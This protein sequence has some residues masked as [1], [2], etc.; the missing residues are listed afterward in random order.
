MQIE[1]R[2]PITLKPHPKNA[3]IHTDKQ[4][5][6]IAK[7]MDN[8]QGSIQPIVVNEQG[9]ILAGHGRWM[10]H[11]KRGD[12][13]CPVITVAG[14][15]DEAQCKFLLSDNQTNAM[16]GSDF[17]AVAEILRDLDSKSI[18]VS[19]MGFSEKE[20][21]KLL[22][23]EAEEDAP[24][25]FEDAGTESFGMRELKES[26][27]LHASD[28]VGPYQLPRLLSKNIPHIPEEM[29]VWMNRHRTPPLGQGQMHYHLFGRESTKGLNPADTV[30]SFY[31]DDVR[32]E[33]VWSKLRDNTQRFLNAGPYALTMPDFTRMDGWPLPKNLWAV[34]RSFYCA[35]YW[36]MAGLPVIPSLCEWNL[37]SVEGCCA[38]IPERA[39]TLSCQI[40]TV[41]GR[42]LKSG[43]G[44]KGVDEDD[45][46]ASI[47][48]G[49]DLLKPETLLVYGGERG[50]TLGQEI[51]KR[52]GVR[53]VGVTNRATAAMD[54]GTERGF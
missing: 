29:V 28:C 43:E 44:G 8:T 54:I 17:D 5:D 19:D 30:I 38:P 22:N 3:K 51:C 32:F 13:E 10:A 16:T 42:T 50:L 27:A 24:D 25:E 45:F 21:D 4:I 41:G 52:H 37:D 11:K 15:S 7:S 40:Q 47:G 39:P 20:L 1:M 9:V 35:L 53:F 14:L 33:R 2:D 18:D 34:Y 12:V 49:L 23:F 31:I 48:V 6:R 46:R 36:Q 26:L